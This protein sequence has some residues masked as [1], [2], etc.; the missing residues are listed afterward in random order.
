MLLRL[1]GSAGTEP[2][3][4]KVVE[5]L[6]RNAADFRLLHPDDFGH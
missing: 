3:S 1:S 4:H 5:V 6:E 2:L